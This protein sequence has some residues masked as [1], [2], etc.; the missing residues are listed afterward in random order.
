MPEVT[1]SLPVALAL[2][3]VFLGLGAGLVFFTVQQ[4]PEIIVPPTVTS[5]PTATSS[6]TLTPT[7]E[8]PTATSTPE[9]TLTP[10]PYI[11]Q[12]GN[13][14]TG[15]AFTFDISV[16]SIIRE[17]N[18]DTNCTIYPG[19]T[20]LIPHPTT[21]PT[22]LPSA[23]LN[24]TE[25][26]AAACDKVVYTVQSGDTLSTIS[27]NYQV[28]MESIRR[29][30]NLSGDVVFEGLPLTIPL[31]ERDASV[32]GGPTSTPTPAPP[33]PGPSL[34]LPADGATF[35]LASDTIT[36]QWASVGALRDNEAY[37]IIIVD[38]TG[39]EERRLVSYAT[40][41]KFIVPSSFLSGSRGIT[42]F[43]WQVGT[44]RQVGTNEEGLPVY[45]EAGALSD[46][47]GFIWSGTVAATPAP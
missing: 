16:L 18:L 24:P 28:P 11:V 46:R 44:V 42:L 1:L 45:Q 7:P 37:I 47:R 43:Y 6:P 36:L 19:Q 5:T 38:A 35:N 14:C 9:P 8:T 15:I 41:T 21:T 13:L 25:A 40:D 34:L 10:F 39:G 27:V 26:Y 20:L 23:T 33:Y 31:C 32:V 12:D 3:A 4:Q 2:V 29:W 17:N 22:A 30:N